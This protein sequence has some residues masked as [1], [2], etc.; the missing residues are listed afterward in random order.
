MSSVH[1]SPDSFSTLYIDGHY[2][3]SK[4]TETLT[5]RN[6]KDDSIVTDKVPIA[7]EADVDEAVSRAEAAFNGPWSTFSAA[8]RT[9]C[10]LKLVDL[11]EDRLLDILTLDSLTT[12]N[13]VSLIPTREK[14]YIKSALV[15]YG[16]CDLLALYVACDIS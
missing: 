5:L 7:C 6:P 4:S 3:P 12:G 2:V 10:F 9:S 16:T 15:Y 14:N 8:Q 11:L 1:Q 13:P